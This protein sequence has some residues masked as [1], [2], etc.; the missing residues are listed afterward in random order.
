M[1]RKQKI[2]LGSLAS[3]AAA[4]VMGSAVA[5]GAPAAISASLTPGGT[6]TSHLGSAQDTQGFTL[7]N[8]TVQRLE[9]QYVTGTVPAPPPG[10][11]LPEGEVNYELPY[12][13]FT[14]HSSGE[15]F[16]KMVDPNGGEDYTLDLHLDA[17][18][19]DK[20][21]VTVLGPS[22]Y[23]VGDYLQLDNYNSGPTEFTLNDAPGGWANKNPTITPG[24]NG[25]TQ[26]EV[27]GTLK[28]MG[29]DL[30][31]SNVTV[32]DDARDPK[33][34]VTDYEQSGSGSVGTETGLETSVT[35]SWD[36]SIS[37]DSDILKAVTLGVSK[38]VGHS[39]TTSNNFG[40]SATQD[41]EAGYT[42]VIY[43][44]VPVIAATGDFSGT[45]GATQLNFVGATFDYP[46][47]T[48]PMEYAGTNIEGDVRGEPQYQPDAGVNNDGPTVAVKHI[49]HP[50]QVKR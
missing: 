1:K 18:N 46:D 8:N 32:D 10:E 43:G 31:Y 13:F 29:S 27:S 26:D 36:T 6:S 48:R 7:H 3:L 41:L 33:V 25:W 45:I 15:V 34:L 22:G 12:S 37:A 16:Y 28:N 20:S 42:S 35:N 2:V 49:S 30:T 17:V 39:V 5:F 47:T 4:G 38:S 14:E 50:K 9:F 23:P 40:T 19:T 21:M 24:V 44:L 11:V